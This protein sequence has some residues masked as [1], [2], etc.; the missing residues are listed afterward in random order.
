MSSD[1]VGKR[2]RARRRVELG[3][4]QTPAPLARAIVELVRRR[5]PDVASV[6]EPTCGAG[7]F[8]HAALEAFPRA[9][10]FGFDISPRHLE[11]ARRRLG[12]MGERVRIELGD[13]FEL[14]WDDL[15]GRLPE[16]ILIVGNP[17]WVTNSTLG[18]LGAKNLPA[19]LNSSRQPGIAALTGQSNF[20]ISEWM[21]SRLLEAFQGRQFELSMLC[22][23]SVARRVMHEAARRGALLH[24]ESRAIDARAHFAA[25]VAAVLLSVRPGS[26]SRGPR[27]RAPPAGWAVYDAI[28]SKSPSR[29]MA[30][31]GGRACSDVAALRAT[32][33]LE[34]RAGERAGR[35]SEPAWRSGIKHDCAPVMELTRRGEAL[36]NGLGEVVELEPDFVFPLFKGSDVARGRQREPRHV[37]ITQSGLGE[38]TSV[39]AARAPATW[40]YLQAHRAR[41]EARRSRIYLRQPAFALFGVGPYA[42]AP[43]KVAICGLYKRLAFTLLRPVEGRPAM[44]D[45]TVYFVPCDTERE[46]A[47]LLAALRCPLVRDFFEARIFWDAKRPITKALLESLSLD[48]LLAEERRVSG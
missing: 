12:G 31:V 3:D 7:V 26:P 32:A 30:V 22:K 46:A 41:F 23:A 13:F 25:E 9:R 28:E 5:S 44:V 11:A 27:R 36:V 29:Y 37:L 33:H 19:K 38:D 39:I 21:I 20:D 45:D 48:T 2:A 47:R 15:A 40:R 8:L 4:W 34:R 16:P 6:L 35:S 42:F 1:W 10:A 43:Y 14:G 17:P 24:G 18:A